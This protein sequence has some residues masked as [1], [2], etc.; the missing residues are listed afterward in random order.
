M[1]QLFFFLNT[2]LG[3]F[4]ATVCIAQSNV[5]EYNIRPDVKKASY[6]TGIF[7]KP[8]DTISLTAGGC[9]QTGGIGKTW[10]RYVDPSGPNSGRLYHGL[11]SI[12]GVTEDL[13]RIMLC[14]NRTFVIPATAA[15]GYIW[16]GY[17]DDQYSDNGYWGRDP[18]TENQCVRQPD[19]FVNIRVRTTSVLVQPIRDLDRDGIDDVTER[20]LLE[21][22]RPYYKFTLRNG[23]Q[24]EYRPADVFWYLNKSEV[25]SSDNE[26]SS[27]LIKNQDLTG[28][29]AILLTAFGG[30]ANIIRNRNFSKYHI[31]PLASVNGVG[32]DPGRHGNNWQTILNNKNIGLYGHVVPV[33]IQA[34]REFDYDHVFSS[35]DIGKTYYKIEYWQ[36]WGYSAAHMPANIGDHEGDWTT[37]QVIYDPE[38]KRI[39]EIAHFAHGMKFSFRFSALR[40]NF[41]IRIDQGNGMEYRGVNYSTSIDLVSHD[42]RF[43]WNMNEYARAQDNVVRVYADPITGEYTHPVVYIENGTHEYYPT[44]HWN[45]YTAPAHK[46]NGYS[47]LTNTP[48]HLGEVEYPVNYKVILQFNGK[49][50]A[51]SPLN[52]PPV[53]PAL[54]R[55]WTWPAT[56][57][58]RWLL[59]T[60]QLPF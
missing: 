8:G 31:N 42:L 3:L 12:P 25:L 53:G 15:S 33:K 9:V 35:S 6:N 34:N 24:D 51:Y 45:Y 21:K 32:N 54:H 52:D 2:F 22:F 39:K 16:L 26:N 56:S 38:N 11:I 1:K 36:F 23:T 10:K 44:E 28:N 49:W 48:I 41:P 29:S 43:T 18:G 40:D 20:Q 60:S 55:Q 57:S 50:G 59:N 58:I 4:G 17:E 47:F 5:H 46:G 27:P 37:V 19:A 13:S 7:V 30:D 14:N